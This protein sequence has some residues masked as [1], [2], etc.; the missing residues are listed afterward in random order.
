[1]P[2]PTVVEFWNAL[3]QS[4]LVGP[5]VLS[6][7]QREHAQRSDAQGADAAAVASWLVGRGL[8]TRWQAKR[9]L[10]GSRGPWFVGEYRLLDRHE[11]PGNVPLFTARHEPSGRVFSIVLLGSRRCD[12]PAIW[13]GIARRASAAIAA[14]DPVLSRTWSIEQADTTRFIVCEQVAGESL[15]RVLTRSGAMSPRVAGALGLRIARSIASLHAAGE[16]HGGL[17]LDAVRLPSGDGPA[18]PDAA[19]VL[20]YP[21]VGDPHLDPPRI[22]LESDEDLERLGTRASFVAPEL[23]RPDAACDARSDV[24]AIGCVLHALLTGQVPGWRGE[25]RATL[26]QAAIS[27]VPPLGPPVVPEE[28][29]TLVSYL[30]TRDPEARYRTAAEAAEAIAAC[31]GLDAGTPLMGVDHSHP[32]LAVTTDASTRP[33]ARRPSPRRTFPSG[34][35]AGAAA[36]VMLVAAGAWLDPFGLF[37]KGGTGGGLPGGSDS[38]ASTEAPQDD[39]G[40]TAP[41]SPDPALV[42]STAT[43]PSAP[44]DSPAPAPAG[45]GPAPRANASPAAIAPVVVADDSLPWA[46]PTHGSALPL[47]YL[48]GGSQL[49][50]GAR[51]AEIM[52]DEEGL[53]FFKALGPLVE[54]AASW[55]ASVTGCGLDGIESVQAGWQAAADGTV[56]GACVVRLDGG[57]TI[58]DQDDFRSRQWGAERET[59]VSGETIHHGPRLAFWTPKA[60]VG[61]VLVVA[62]TDFMEDIVRGGTSPPPL[63]G[64]L[65]TLVPTLD[66]GRHLTL[67]V[68][69]HYLFTEGR[70]ILSGPLERLAEPLESFFGE[71]VRAA[72]LSAHFGSDFYA[73]LDAVSTLDKAA[74]ALAPVLRERIDALPDSVEEWIAALAPHPHGRRLVMRLPGMLRALV[75]NLRSGAEGQV[76]VL[77]AYL[78]RHAGHNL[79]LAGELVLAQAPGAG[80]AAVAATSGATPAAAAPQDA[81]AKLKRPMTLVFARDTLEKSVQMIADEIGVPIEINGGDL[82]LEGITKN[83]SFGLTERDSTADAI[84]RVILGKSNAEGKLV[85]VVRR[86]D[87]AEK[88][89]ITTRAAVAKRGDTLPPG[90]E[91]TKAPEEKR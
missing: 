14:T 40:A 83:Q 55:L 28:V 46:A 15:G 24:Y 68:A 34:A 75:A 11:H 67:A 41:S 5:A 88:I 10:A 3:G 84:L 59:Q 48:P 90:F 43:P 82:Q 54:S 18:D 32:Q 22:P 51:P 21:L 20:Q 73:E 39:G 69:T 42:A 52:A 53:L 29:G 30:T 12:D 70:G 64:D 31:F 60:D 7:I 6:S 2:Q 85:Y 33:A 79:A 44:G 65:E 17:S 86:Q 61:R 58:P 45:V 36:L 26:R 47:T 4:R 62:P 56:L 57:R 80:A 13:P 72:A 38:S 37:D 89:E 77:N 25:P 91:P 66:G 1:M 63:P 74:A 8:L 87:G 16:V 49:L 76:A 78:P 9:L 27:G 35:I 23:T 81:L 71:D 50:L 19:R